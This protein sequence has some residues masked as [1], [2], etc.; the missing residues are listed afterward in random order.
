MKKRDKLPLDDESIV[1]LY[2]QR[3]EKAIEETDFKYK[4]YLL[5][6]A[7]NVLHEPLDCEECLNDTYLGAWNAIPPTRPNVLKAFLTVVVRRVAI[8]RYHRNLKKSSVP[9]EMTVSLSELEDFIIGD[10]DISTDFDAARL[11]R[12]ISDFVRSL[13]ERR[14]FIFVSRYYASEPIDSIASD[15]NLSRSMINKELAAIKTALRE[16]LESEGYNV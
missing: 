1:E 11:G 9:S 15:L 3:N 13:S 12:V 6:I 8:K 5:S 16:K 2:W 14:Q 10:E 4:K 7:Y